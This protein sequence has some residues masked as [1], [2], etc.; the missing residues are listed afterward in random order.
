M[1]M[2]DM[3]RALQCVRQ[4]GEEGKMT[5]RLHADIQKLNSHLEKLQAK[6]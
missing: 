4:I 1:K 2:D 3:N 5:D 6:I